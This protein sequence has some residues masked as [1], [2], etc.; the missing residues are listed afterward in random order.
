MV[1][2]LLKK[3]KETEQTQI[4]GEVL[5]WAGVYLLQVSG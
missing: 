3:S 4:F 2:G 5:T 1:A